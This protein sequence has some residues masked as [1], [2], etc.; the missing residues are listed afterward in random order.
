MVLLLNLCALVAIWAAPTAPSGAPQTESGQKLASLTVDVVDPQGAM[1]AK[2]HVTIAASQGEQRTI[3][4]IADNGRTTFSKLS[5]GI[6]KVSARAQGFMTTEKAVRVESQPLRILIAL[7]IWQC[8]PCPE[9]VAP[10]IFIPIE[11]SI[12]T[13][14]IVPYPIQPLPEN[15]KE[16]KKK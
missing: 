7:P 1:V 12:A 9:V 2:A 8:S 3:E 11:T 13:P 16:K 14:E 4:E 5:P 15:K 6:Y 10:P